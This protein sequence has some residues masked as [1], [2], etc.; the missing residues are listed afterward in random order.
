MEFRAVVAFAEFGA[1]VAYPEKVRQSVRTPV[2][3]DDEASGEASGAVKI[4]QG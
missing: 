4:R 2:N 3:I 1:A